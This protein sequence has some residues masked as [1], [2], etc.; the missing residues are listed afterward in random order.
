MVVLVLE[1]RRDERKG[2]DCGMRWNYLV[3]VFL[4]VMTRF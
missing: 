2:M 3:W 4:D 1:V